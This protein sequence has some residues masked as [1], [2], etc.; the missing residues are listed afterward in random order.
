MYASL[1][2]HLNVVEFLVS[3]KADIDAKR[4][5]RVAGE[6]GALLDGGRERMGR[7]QQ[8][9]GCIR[10]EGFGAVASHVVWV[11]CGFVLCVRFGALCVV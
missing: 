10:D 8:E 3:N 6:E 2:G 5:V 9:E 1:N 11:V 4:E 7:V